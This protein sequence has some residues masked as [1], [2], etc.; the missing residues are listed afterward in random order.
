MFE[1]AILWADLAAFLGR[2]PRESSDYTQSEKLGKS[3]ILRE[4]WA[5]RSM[6]WPGRPF[7][8]R[9]WDGSEGQLMEMEMLDAR[10]PLPESL[11]EDGMWE[12]GPDENGKPSREKPS[13][14]AL[15]WRRTM[16]VRMKIATVVSGFYLMERVCGGSTG[17]LQRQRA[18]GRKKIV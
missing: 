5:M 12:V 10:D 6:V 2:G 1:R 11:D 9:F 18:N 8:R 13:R 17:Y 14:A 16:S 3:S 15:A 4:D 7:E